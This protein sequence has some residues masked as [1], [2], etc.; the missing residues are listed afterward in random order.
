MV[1]VLFICILLL[2][3]L[4]LRQRRWAYAAY[5]VLSLAYFPIKAGWPF[6]PRA[7]QLALD[8]ALA[9]FSLTNYAHIILFAMFFIISA[10]QFGSLRTVSAR[11]LAFAALMTLA[12]GALVEISQGITGRGNCRL[13]D[14]IPDAAGVVIAATLLVTF[15]KVM[16]ARHD[17]LSAS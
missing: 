16:R 7:C 15:Q 6:Q 8:W 5:V 10:A 11:Q 1:A 12:M 17:R 4:S 13:R 14:L 9:R 3:V 2:G